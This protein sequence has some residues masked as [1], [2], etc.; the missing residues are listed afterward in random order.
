VSYV[1]CL[2]KRSKETLPAGRIFSST[3]FSQITKTLLHNQTAVMGNGVRFCLPVVARGT[4]SCPRRTPRPLLLAGSESEAGR[5][6]N[7]KTSVGRFDD[8]CRFLYRVCGAGKAG[9]YSP[10]GH[11]RMQKLLVGLTI[12]P[13]IEGLPRIT[14]SLQIQSPDRER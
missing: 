11:S 9:N 3:T 1:H 6:Q 5:K 13:D 7:E 8:G 4:S 12:H 10:S 2:S 14:A